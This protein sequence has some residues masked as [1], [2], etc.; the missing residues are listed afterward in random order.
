[1]G[2]QR[3]VIE[4]YNIADCEDGEK[5]PRIWTQSYSFEKNLVCG[6]VRPMRPTLD[7]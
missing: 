1:M 5:E 7:L 2:S 4:T 6:H 3:E